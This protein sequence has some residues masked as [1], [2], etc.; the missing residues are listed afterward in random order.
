MCVCVCVCVYVCWFP[1]RV[2]I[3][4]RQN[5]TNR[6]FS[7]TKTR[8]KKRKENEEMRQMTYTR[9]QQIATVLFPLR[10]QNAIVSFLSE[11]TVHVSPRCRLSPNDRCLC[12]QKIYWQAR[13]VQGLQ[14][15]ASWQLSA[16]SR[17]LMDSCWTTAPSA[18][19]ET[20][21]P[22]VYWTHHCP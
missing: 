22:H 4:L 17:N 16:L 18:Q 14:P 11:D 6:Q 12:E 8:K 20:D 10:L 7:L 5:H 13:D 9:R 15:D 1:F 2:L 3:S 21:M 19:S